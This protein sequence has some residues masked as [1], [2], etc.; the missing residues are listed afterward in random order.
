MIR[1]TFLCAFSLASAGLVD[2]LAQTPEPTAGPTTTPGAAA[3][4]AAAV[5]RKTWPVGVTKVEIP[6]SDGAK[7]LAMWYAPKKS[8]KRPLLVALHTWSS[9]YAS[10]GGDA[11]YADWCLAQDWAFVHPDFRGPNATPDSMGSDRAVKDVVEA[12]AWAK[13]QASVDESRIY[14]IGVSGGGHMALQMA[15]REPQLWTAVSAW[16]GISD[17]GQWHADHTKGGKPD[18]YAQNIEAALGGS[19]AMDGPAKEEAWKRSP[20]SHLG[21][22]SIVPLDIHA[23][24]RDGRAGSVPFLHSLKAFNAVVGTGK[25]ALDPDKMEEYYKTQEV[26]SG[27]QEAGE[28]LSYGA[29]KPLFRRTAGKTRVTIF[30]GGHEIVH[31]A[32]LNWLAQQERGKPV[33]WDLKD[34]IKLDVVGGESGK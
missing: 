14:L 29:W 10:A 31:Q 13:K 34:F 7:Q 25:D 26:P 9:H 24:V 23:G 5:N 1:R 3:A 19:P 4:S 18:R 6:C 21:Q 8:G 15:A 33:V 11:V 32:A 28:D 16:C 22:A 20:L 17:I 2:L 27:W 12:L 30:D